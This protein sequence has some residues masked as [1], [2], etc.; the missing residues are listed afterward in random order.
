MI[1]IL[2][3]FDKKEASYISDF[4]FYL[5]FLS[6]RFTTHRTAGEEGGYIV[7]SSLPLSPA[8]QALRR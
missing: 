5:G 7:K 8:S 3:Y 4:F 2:S 1:V 6:R